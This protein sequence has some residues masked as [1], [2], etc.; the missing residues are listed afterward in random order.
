[1]RLLDVVFLDEGIEL[2]LLLQEVHASCFGCCLL[3]IPYIGLVA[4]SL[5]AAE[6]GD[7]QQKSC[8]RDFAASPGMVQRQ[9]SADELSPLLGIGKRGSK[10]FRSLL[11][12][13]AH[14]YM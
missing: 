10:N 4:T 11:M 2:T 1:M 12:Q 6:L 13:C 7:G 3:Q 8:A 9:H 5:L 14:V